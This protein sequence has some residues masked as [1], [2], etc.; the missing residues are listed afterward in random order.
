MPSTEIRAAL[1]EIQHAVEVP[2]LDD[3]AFRARVRTER[4]RRYAGQALAAG[5]VAAAAAAVV[6]GFA[7][8]PHGPTPSGHRVVQGPAASTAPAPTPEGPAV[9]RLDGRLEVLQ[10]GDG[11]Y[12]SD[13]RIQQV[14]GRTS[15]GDAVVIGDDALLWRVPLAADGEP[16]DPVPLADARPVVNAWLDKAGTTVAFV[17]RDDLMH[18]R[19]LGADQD[20]ETIPLLGQ[21]TDLV[22]T[23]GTAWIED[24]GDRLSLRYPHESFEVRVAAD[25][26]GAEL[27]GHTLA[28]LTTGGVEFHDAAD[29]GLRFARA[30][31]PSGALSPDGTA[32][33]ARVG[34]GLRVLDTTTGAV[35]ELRGVGPDLVPTSMTWQDDDRFLVLAMSTVRTGNLVLL[36]CSV[37]RSACDERY[38]DP[39]GT[40]EI[41]TQ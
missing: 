31:V 2:A 4:R 30:D 40:L 19:P 23:D 5:T 14:V 10:P 35:H 34:D 22:A 13:L 8:S 38:D 12:A 15:A 11:G 29:G 25:P 26:V 37:A 41:A 33:A 6:A 18:L 36:D 21:Q 1:A 27:A 24:E 3:L 9:V 28:V 20:T 7:L 16:G 39:T 17:T 32:Y